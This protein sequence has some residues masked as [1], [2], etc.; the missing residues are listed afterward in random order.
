MEQSR[1]PHAVTADSATL[2]RAL[3]TLSTLQYLSPAYRR[4]AEWSIAAMPS[5]AIVAV[6]GLFDW[7]LLRLLQHEGQRR[8]LRVVYSTPRGALSVAGTRPVAALPWVGIDSVGW[9]SHAAYLEILDTLPDRLVRATEWE[10][11]RDLAANVHGGRFTS[12]PRPFSGGESDLRT[13]VAFTVF[14]YVVWLDPRPELV[15]PQELSNVDSLSRLLLRLEPAFAGTAVDARAVFAEQQ[16][17]IADVWLHRGYAW[18]GIPHLE[19]ALSLHPGNGN[20]WNSLAYH[21]LVA[22]DVVAA[23]TALRRAAL[24]SPTLSVTL[25]AATIAR[26]RGDADS[27]LRALDRGRV[28][29]D[30]LRATEP[31]STWGWSL[32]H[33][34]R[35]RGDTTAARPAF[36]IHT[37]NARDAF[38]LHNRALA[39]ALRGDFA[40]ADR[41]RREARRLFD[42]PGF[43]CLMV[44]LSEATRA[45]TPLSSRA[46]AW[47]LRYERELRTSA[48]CPPN[49]G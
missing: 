12:P 2:R 31:D 4:L 27:A 41:S 14:R 49:P 33:L 39:L 20:L 3:D 32:T 17:W 15:Q 35:A 40:E 43:R 36:S 48:P 18:R 5:E 29:L 23:D 7:L 46:Q 13:M 26:L 42:P 9:N 16:G 22:G 1:H 37:H 6:D 11:L 47:Y 25:N 8:D 24:I 10:S 45:F 34:P 30:S 28:S 38:Y 19:E 44:S 21:A